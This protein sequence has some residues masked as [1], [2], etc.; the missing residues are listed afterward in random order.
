MRLASLALLLLWPAPTRA[1]EMSVEEVLRAAEKVSPD[2][3]AAAARE[4]QAQDA[5]ELGRSAYFP[6]LDAQG[7]QSWGFAGSN[8]A[9]G[10]GGLM[11]SPFRSGPTGGLV[12]KMTLFDLS[13]GHG[14]D[15]SRSRLEAARAQTRVARYTLDQ[16][17]LRVYFD[18]V[19]DRGQMEA[20]REVG[21]E[22]A[23]VVKDVD[24]LVRTGQ[25]SPVE[26]LLIGDQAD[27]AEMT[28][29]AYAER[30]RI[31]L[32]RLALLTALPEDGLACP[33]PASL[34]ESAL[35]AITPGTASPAV[36]RAEAEAA[37]AKSAAEQAFAENYPTVT[38]LGSVGGMEKVRLVQRI[39][40]SAGVGIS[41]P[42]FEGFRTR[43][44]ASAARNASAERDFA[45][46]GARL[47]LDE[48]DAA[49]D[50]VMASS[51][52][53]LAYLDRELEAAQ[54][55][56]ELAKQR[57]LSF[58]GPLVDVRESIRNLARVRAQRNDAKV[59][60]LLALGAKAVLHGGRVGP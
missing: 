1:A 54:R 31:A 45:A 59:D 41:L 6:T 4:A 3:K 56:L 51:R 11:S 21:A 37:A 28:A 13:R 20:W 52:V 43:S 48:A 23:K 33:A 57:Y 9:L 29:A 24:R 53:K 46:L 47:E 27:D 32:R 5:V 40:Y 42:L 15:A 38:A 35:A 8:G 44:R 14:V 12:S 25:H 26:R 18:A 16:A 49:Y 10:L 50:E 55:T 17:A 22:I 60:L 7:V 34:S 36:E 19:R 30:Y 2:L 39:D 58:E